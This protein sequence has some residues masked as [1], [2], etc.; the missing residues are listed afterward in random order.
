MKIEDIKLGKLYWFNYYYF[1]LFPTAKAANFAN[2]VNW[3]PFKMSAND[4]MQV[5]KFWILWYDD[6]DKINKELMD[7]CGITQK[8]YNL[9]HVK[10]GEIFSIVE[11]ASSKLGE[12]YFAAKILAADGSM[13]W[14]VFDLDQNNL[15]PAE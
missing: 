8:V 4:V 15:F 10:P 13:G 11:I 12:N 14:T 6:K 2:E 5:K 7:M 1:L 9:G 3:A